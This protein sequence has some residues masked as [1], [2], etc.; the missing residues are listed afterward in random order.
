LVSPLQIR[1]RKRF[2][3]ELKRPR[4]WSLDQPTVFEAVR[5]LDPD[6]VVPYLGNGLR[7]FVKAFPQLADAKIAQRWADY[8]DATPNAIPVISGA[9]RVPGP[10]IGTGFLGH[11][12]GIGPAAGKLMTDISTMMRHSSIRTRFGC[13]ASA[14]ARK[15]QSMRVSERHIVIGDGIWT[16]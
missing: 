9:A 14:M 2:L 12:F 3:D 5:T 7:E 4:R 8:I 15:P 13:R 6:P 11:G 1:V 16:R 10:F